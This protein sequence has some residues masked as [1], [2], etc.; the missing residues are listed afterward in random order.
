M[1]KKKTMIENPV[2][3]IKAWFIYYINIFNLQ[4]K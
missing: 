4:K 2:I 3:L 1:S